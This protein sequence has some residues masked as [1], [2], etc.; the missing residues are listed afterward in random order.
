MTA[1]AS[2][3][4][5][6]E[7]AKAFL[8]HAPKAIAMF[9]RQMR[10]ILATNKWCQDY[11]LAKSDIIGRSHYEIFPEIPDDWKE[12]HKRTLNGE[13]LSSDADPFPRADG[14]L[15]WVKWRNVPWYERDGSVGGIIMFTEVVSEQ[16]LMRMALE[17]AHDGICVVTAKGT[18]SSV[19]DQYASLLGWQAG[20]MKG[21]P[22]RKTVHPDDLSTMELAYQ[23]MCS[24]GRA[25]EEVRGIRKDGSILQQRLTIVANYSRAGDV[26]GHFC[27]IQDI[28]AEKA[29]QE[30][31]S[32]KT[33]WLKLTESYGHV[34]HW[35]V[36]LVQSK[37]V[38]SNEVYRLHGVD[39]G[40]DEP[41][42][43]AAI[44]F[45]HEDDRES[46]AKAVEDAITTFEPFEFEHRLIS[47]DGT[48]RWVHSKGQ[49]RK[50]AQGQLV[51]I[52]GIF[53]D[54]TSRRKQEELIRATKERFE[55]ATKS[56]D[57][58]LWETDIQTGT[59][60]LSDMIH[61][62][63]GTDSR[64]GSVDWKF[65]HDRLNPHDR[66]LAHSVL[67]NISA[68][69]DLQSGTLRV[70]KADGT[71]AHLLF[72]GGTIYSDEGHPQRLLGSFLDDTEETVAEEF[73]ELIWQ[74]LTDQTMNLNQKLSL[75]L[76]RTTAYFGMEFGI[77][78]HWD[79]HKDTIESA[80][81]SRATIN[82]ID[83]ISSAQILMNEVRK[84]RRTIG[85]DILGEPGTDIKTVVNTYSLKSSLITPI[86]IEGRLFGTLGFY[87]E[88][89][90][91]KAFKKSDLQLL[92]LISRWVGFEMARTHHLRNLEVSEERFSLAAKGASVGIWDWV[93]VT[94]SEVVWSDQFYRL[95]GYE[96]GDIPA[97]LDSFLSILHPDDHEKTFKA[98]QD[99]FY[100]NLP[101]KI[102][103]RLL[104]KDENYKWFL[105]T[106]QAVW[107]K[108]GQPRRMIGSI[109]DIQ[110]Q[111]N[112]ELLKDEFVS[113]VSH[114]LRTPLT[115]IVGSIGLI[116][117]GRF[118]QIDPEMD[119]LLR[120]AASNGDRLV[121]LINDILDIEKIT[122]GTIDFKRERLMV[123][124]LVNQSIEL[125]GTM[126]LQM[127]TNVRV[128]DR[129]NGARIVGD[130]HRLHQAIT[131]LLSNAAKF[132]PPNAPITVQITDEDGEVGI[133]VSD[134]GQGIPADQLELIFDRFVQVESSMTR[135][136][137]GSGLGL[138]ITQAIAEAHQGRINVSSQVG[139]G[140]TF[141]L[142]FPNADA[143]IEQKP[144]IYQDGSKLTRKQNS[145]RILHVEDDKDTNLLLRH[146]IDDVAE[147]V[148]APNVT[149]A[150]DAL[151]REHFD[152]IVLDLILNEE[153]GET[154]IDFIA[155]DHTDATQVIV[156]SAD[157]YSVRSLPSFVSGVFT[158]SSISQEQFRE[159]LLT[160]LRH[161]GQ[162]ILQSNTQQKRHSA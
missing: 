95:L 136:K 21:M 65:V 38:W 13:M 161:A 82:Q 12:L 15:D 145:P 2:N 91:T 89:P 110:T 155:R 57:I 107:D 84:A 99:H 138:S 79:G 162:K 146:L 131:N 39:P 129:S 142:I 60:T 27:F 85:H 144:T 1:I 25:V 128:E 28:T 29:E 34:G 22:W 118:G 4:Y 105:G 92:E 122:A 88:K 64:L 7:F 152:L 56:A 20:E 3:V 126:L 8:E 137:G 24:E 111:K 134:R 135:N 80:F 37:I 47:L 42:L 52:F 87:S 117:S 157:G 86:S 6:Q 133:H 103:Y 108:N 102:E 151:I 11:R 98:V 115:S 153:R 69:G 73:R 130:Q 148:W 120:I 78:S 53:Q 132:S 59:I 104:C 121:R 33:E 81:P 51:G 96:P 124:D 62:I 31:L 76:T 109:M 125:N 127:E 100:H 45:Y 94:G 41:D 16:V 9:D 50:N 23:R 55:L 74:T 93:D 150:K 112:A 70:Q 71:Y 19:N 140:S 5:F 147:V 97:S 40:Q 158:K 83:F 156:Y 63:L 30:D 123:S 139:K 160:A 141:S 35:Y 114:E 149:A 49:P 54:V 154:I 159:E 106:G 119:K 116:R 32:Q 68:E 44:N 58:G 143:L 48:E 113:T 17:N 75:I 43:E 67:H 66:P 77:L 18:Y 14:T 101:F 72:R 26:A 61:E 10:Y 90:R 46:V 36:D